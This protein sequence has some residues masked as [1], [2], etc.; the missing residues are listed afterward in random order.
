[1]PANLIRGFLHAEDKIFSGSSNANYG[2]TWK[3]D[4]STKFYF[5]T[6]L[7]NSEK[8]A[9]KIL[10]FNVWYTFYNNDYRQYSAGFQRKK[11]LSYETS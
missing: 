10:T 11:D 6:N 4:D 2:P 8:S 7:V 3:F 5:C 1:L 9:C